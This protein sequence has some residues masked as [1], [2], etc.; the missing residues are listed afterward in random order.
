MVSSLHVVAPECAEQL[1]RLL[2]DRGLRTLQGHLSERGFVGGEWLAEYAQ[3][4][5][6][7][8]SGCESRPSWV[9]WLF[10]PEAESAT[11]LL[12]LWAEDDRAAWRALS[13]LQLH[14]ADVVEVRSL[15]R[16]LLP[17]LKRW[18]F[19][20]DEFE[21]LDAG[22]DDYSHVVAPH[23]NVLPPAE[24][25]AAL[26]RR[27]GAR[28]EALRQARMASSAE[29]EALA[30]ARLHEFSRRL[31]LIDPKAEIDVAPMSETAETA[32]ARGRLAVLAVRMNGHVMSW[33]G[34]IDRCASI[35]CMA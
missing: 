15:P 30:I 21:L 11:Y 9:A 1:A 33:G 12:S 7:P 5:L 26:A 27:S 23:T 2:S 34:E 20:H 10:A 16:A 22:T 13:A 18:A 8:D 25:S 29:D 3:A 14:H 17:Q 6:A 31:L 32:C 28:L 19:E 24:C 35:K 4:Q